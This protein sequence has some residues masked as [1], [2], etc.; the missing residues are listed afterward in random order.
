MAT[1]EK[2]IMTDVTKTANRC[3]VTQTRRT[4][5]KETVGE[6]VAKDT[7]VSDANVGHVENVEENLPKSGGCR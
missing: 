4:I 7:P 5:T 1:T 3:I 2:I 6:V